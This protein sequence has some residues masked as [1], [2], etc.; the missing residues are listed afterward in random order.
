MDKTFDWFQV[1]TLMPTALS[2]LEERDARGSVAACI[3]LLVCP[4]K[5]LAEWSRLFGNHD[6]RPFVI[7]YTSHHHRTCT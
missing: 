4:Q 1:K 3:Y 7:D 2:G 6:G 5:P